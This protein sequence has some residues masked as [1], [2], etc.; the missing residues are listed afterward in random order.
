MDAKRACVQAL[1]TPRRLARRMDTCHMLAF[2][3]RRAEAIGWAPRSRRYVAQ[4]VGRRDTQ[5][6]CKANDGG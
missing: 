3:A 2:A 4:Q 6:S 5:P 1:R